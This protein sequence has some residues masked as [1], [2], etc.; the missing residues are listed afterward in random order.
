MGFDQR[1]ADVVTPS[2]QQVAL[3]DP[4]RY[5]KLN[6]KLGIR[7]NGLGKDFLGLNFEETSC[8]F[9]SRTEGGI[10]ELTVR[11]SSGTASSSGALFPSADGIHSEPAGNSLN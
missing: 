2:Y 11:D 10:G 7:V 5:L 1:E 9:R 6:I 3:L 8:C 4:R